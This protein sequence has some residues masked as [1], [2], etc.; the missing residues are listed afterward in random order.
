MTEV[1]T[2]QTSDESKK[3]KIEIVTNIYFLISNDSWFDTKTS[4]KWQLEQMLSGRLTQEWFWTKLFFFLKTNFWQ[5]NFNEQSFHW[6]HSLGSLIV[7][8]EEDNKLSK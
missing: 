4:G 2:L 3:I 5:R 6:T 8:N 7:N 1:E